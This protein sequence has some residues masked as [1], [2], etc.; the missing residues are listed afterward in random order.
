L[1]SIEPYYRT[2]Q[3]VIHSDGTLILNKGILSGGTKLTHD[4]TVN[5]GKPRLIVQLDDDKIIAPE[6][7]INW[8]KGH[9]INTLNIAGP[10]ESKCPEGIYAAAFAYLEKIFF[11]L[12][13]I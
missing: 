11:M 4:F 13:G 9:L 1:E 5:Y 3:N 2:E 12:K 10:R 7:V 8:I 6:H